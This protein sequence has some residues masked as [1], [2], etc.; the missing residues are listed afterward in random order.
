MNRITQSSRGN[1]L[2]TQAI[3]QLRTS[4]TYY[5][6]NDIET[7]NVPQE[8][9]EQF[10][11]L[12]KTLPNS[13]RQHLAVE[14]CTA[15]KLSQPVHCDYCWAREEFC[16]CGKF[17]VANWTGVKKNIELV[18]LMTYREF[19]R[20]SNTAKVVLNTLPNTKFLL[21]G[22]PIHDEILKNM[23]VTD[24][25]HEVYVMFPST[26]SLPIHKT[27]LV[28]Q[29]TDQVVDGIV[30]DNKKYTII[31]LDGTWREARRMNKNIPEE[32]PRI[33]LTPVNDPIFEH[34]RKQTVQKVGRTSTLEAVVECFREIGMDNSQ[35]TILLDNMKTLV[36]EV[37]AMS[38]KEAINFDE[39]DDAEE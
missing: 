39:D 29:P 24:D 28:L 17:K 5:S 15:R 33:H 16:M 31:V 18:F 20:S 38:N 19:Y 11:Q 7:R 34:L 26:G 21:K 30:D 23:L 9:D 37:R 13:Q 32:V 14:R 12:L 35:T 8:H 36:N 10:V 22:L 1:L 2:F 3:N 4:L 27:P 6:L 25:T